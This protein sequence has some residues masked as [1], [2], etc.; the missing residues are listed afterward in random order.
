MWEEAEVPAVRGGELAASHVRFASG[1][2]CVVEVK[3][4]DVDSRGEGPDLFEALVRARRGL[5]AHD[6]LLG[7]NGA[8]RDVF[9]S[10]MQRQAAGGRRAYVLTMPR[11]TARPPVVDIFAPAPELS[12]LATVD[13]QR[14]WFDRWRESGPGEGGSS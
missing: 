1:D 6:V 10:A 7:C 12:A 4:G 13:E 2:M 3:V 8:R 9:P 11:T 14:A 5:E